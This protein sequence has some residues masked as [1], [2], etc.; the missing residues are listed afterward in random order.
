MLCCHPILKQ[1]QK[2]GYQQE[3]ELLEELEELQEQ[4][5]LS[6]TVRSLELTPNRWEEYM[7]YHPHLFLLSKLLNILNINILF[8]LFMI[9]KKVLIHMSILNWY[10]ISSRRYCSMAIKNRS[11]STLAS[12]ATSRCRFLTWS[13]EG[14]YGP[15][16]VI[17]SIKYLWTEQ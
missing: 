6:R 14:S 17:P 13:I 9:R 3:L 4:P 8:Y 7:Q 15:N 12:V 16:V 5:I 1:L 2:Q 11:S 10:L